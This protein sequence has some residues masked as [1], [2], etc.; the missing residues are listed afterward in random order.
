MS[1]QKEKIV[2]IAYGDGGELGNFKL[3]ADTLAKKLKK[4]YSKVIVEYTNRDHKF[5]DLIKSVDSSKEELAELHVF[6]HA[7][8]AGLF[9]GYKDQAI[10][11]LRQRAFAKALNS[12][13]RLSYRQV[14]NI[15]VGAIQTDDFKVGK[16]L[17][18]QDELRKKF[19]KDG[20]IKIWGC[21]SGVNGWV[22]SDG[23]VVDPNDKTEPYYWRAFNEFYSPKPS[24]AQVF[25]TFFNVP[26]YGATSGANVHV[27]HKNNWISSAE[28]K[29]QVGHWPSGSLPHR[30]IPESGV[31]NEYLP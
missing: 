13:S 3:F 28:Y 17:A 25:A 22:Y 14:V 4:V 29:K 26:V 20:I 11:M 15:E 7:I 27:K 6:S 19:A 16:L 31:Y 2:V 8:G 12:N 10:S 24:I 9:L 18:S 5:F 21:N 1:K 23:G 30:L